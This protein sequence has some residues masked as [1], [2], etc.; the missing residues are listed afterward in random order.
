MINI[1]AL[2]IALVAFGALMYVVFD[3]NIKKSK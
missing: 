2:L 1:I 3:I